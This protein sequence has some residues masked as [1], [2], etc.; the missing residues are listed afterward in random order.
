MTAPNRE[1]RQAVAQ[2]LAWHGDKPEVLCQ[3][4]EELVLK[5]FQKGL[6]TKI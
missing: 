3:K 4:L 2:I 5:W 6:D 1:I